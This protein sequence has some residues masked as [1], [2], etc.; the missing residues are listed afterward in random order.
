MQRASTVVAILLVT[1]SSGCLFGP[2][3]EC[4]AALTATDCNRAVEASLRM[5]GDDDRSHVTRVVV[6]PGCPLYQRGCLHEERVISLDISFA[7]TSQ[8][9]RFSVDRTNWKAGGPTYTSPAPSTP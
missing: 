9:A 2:S 5:L 3:I 1:L 6:A 8:R 7:G 4:D